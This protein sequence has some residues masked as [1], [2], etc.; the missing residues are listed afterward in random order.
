MDFNTPFIFEEWNKKRKDAESYYKPMD[1]VEFCDIFDLGWAQ[2][3]TNSEKRIVQE[4]YDKQ[5]DKTQYI[6]T[7]YKF[8]MDNIDFRQKPVG[9]VVALTIF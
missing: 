1:Y 2:N 8:Y 6:P 4:R 3:K 7:A 5:E 9:D